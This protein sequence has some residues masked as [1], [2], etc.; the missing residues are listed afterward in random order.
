MKLSKLLRTTL[1]IGF[2]ASISAISKADQVGNQLA[3]LNQKFDQCFR[4]LGFDS[5]LSGISDKVA[6]DTY[7]NQAAS[8]KYLSNGDFPSE[9]EKRIILKWGT[10]RENCYKLKAATY[11]LVPLIFGSISVASDIEQQMLVLDL[12]M[13]KLTYRDFAIKRQDIETR[14]N[15]Q[16][17][18]P[19]NQY[20]MAIAQQNY[21]NRLQQIQQQQQLQQQLYQSKLNVPPRTTQTNCGWQG[22]QWVC[23]TGATGI[24]WGAFDPNY[25]QKLGNTINQNH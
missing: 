23:N 13:G 10:K 8:F 9:G 11:S 18:Q 16:I 15:E 2:S 4:A 14:F 6:L 19:L 25:P 5:E 22:N 3:L 12:Y 24:D 17:A 1:L 21:R 20:N 7:A